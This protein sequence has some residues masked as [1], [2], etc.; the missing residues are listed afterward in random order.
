MKQYSQE[1]RV[2][3]TFILG[4]CFRNCLLASRVYAERYPDRPHPDK[5]AF[6]ELLQT[7]C[8]TG[9]VSYKKQT[10]EKCVVNNEDNEFLVL[11][12]VVENPNVSSREISRQT[13]I[14]QTSVCRIL[15]KHKYHPYHIQLHQN[16]YGRDFQRRLDFC[17]WSLEKVGEEDDFFKF[18]LFTDEANF[19]NNGLVNRHNFHYY[20]TENR[21]LYRTV[22][23]QNRWSLNVFGGIVGDHVIGPH[24]FDGNL[25]GVTFLRFLKKEFSV[26]LD[27]VSLDSR[28]KMWLQLDGAPPHFSTNVRNYLDREFPNKWIG[29]GGPHVFPPRSPDLTS[30]DFFFWGYIKNLVYNTPPTT[31]D[32]MKI[33][34]EHAFATVTP[35]ILRNVRRSFEKRVRLCIEENGHHI[36]HLL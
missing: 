36:E 5:R 13:G 28:N 10:K 1:E 4:E 34:I 31:A 32:D 3:M 7:F 18:V 6:E 16:L 35:D 23:R 24:F 15:K 33:R 17:L 22:D 30:M 29:R 11:G 21:H 27:D 25:N 19:H 9:S 26:L 2:D 14:S 8:E 12:S 20:D